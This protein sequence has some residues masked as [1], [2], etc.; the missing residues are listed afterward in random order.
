MMRRLCRVS[1]TAVGLPEVD[2]ASSVPAGEGLFL[3]G[4][5]APRGQSMAAKRTDSA[6]LR[7]ISGHVSFAYAKLRH[8]GC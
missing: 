5:D 4:L 8:C 7:A 6:Q 2:L 3:C 1:Q